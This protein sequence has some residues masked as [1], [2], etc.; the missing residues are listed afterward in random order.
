MEMS[1][2]R[3]LNTGEPAP[4][5]HLIF[6]EFFSEPA[7]AYDN[8]DIFFKWSRRLGSASL[9]VYRKSAPTLGPEPHL[10]GFSKCFYICG[11]SKYMVE[12]D[13]VKSAIVEA[14][15]RHQKDMS[16]CP[17][18]STH[19]C[20]MSDQPSHGFLLTLRDYQR[21][22][23]NWMEKIESGDESLYYAP[24][25]ATF[26]DN[27]QYVNVL[28]D[29]VISR[30]DM[31]GITMR[32]G[33]IA[34]KPGVGKTI[35]T[36]ALMHQRP[37]AG[38]DD[39]LYSLKEERFVSR[40]TIIFAPNNLC[41]QWNQEI[42][43]CFGDTLKVHVLKGKASLMACKLTD[44]LTAD[45]IVV[46]YALLVNGCY[47]GCK[48]SGRT[49]HHYKS[50]WNFSD[51]GAVKK[52]C[53]SKTGVF[54][55]TWIHF[56]RVVCD[57]FHEIGDKATAIVQQI[58]SMSSDHFWGLTGTPRLESEDSVQFAAEFLKCFEPWRF[59]KFEAHR[60]IRHR[61][62]CNEPAPDF[63][64]PIHEST[65]IDLSAQER[66]MYH[67]MK[68]AGGLD[69]S[70]KDLLM[71][72]SHYQIAGNV[73]ANMGQNGFGGAGAVFPFG[74]VQA[75]FIPVTKPRTIEEVIVSIQGHRETQIA[76]LEKEI[77]GLQSQIRTYEKDIREIELAGPKNDGDDED[78][79][80]IN[81][82]AETPLNDKLPKNRQKKRDRLKRSIAAAE[83]QIEARLAKLGPLR[84]Q[85]NFFQNFIDGYI[86]RTET[87]SCPVCLADDEE[88]MENEVLA[89]LPC[90]H[91]LCQPC[92]AAVFALPGVDPSCPQCRRPTAR[93]DVIFLA[94][95]RTE[96]ERKEAQKAAAEKRKQA[97]AEAKSSKLSN[98]I[99]TE[100]EDGG[101]AE[102]PLDFDKFGTKLSNV[103]SFI[104]ETLSA[105]PDHRVIVFVQWSN[106]A[107]YV[108]KAL[109]SLLVRTARLYGGWQM[110]ERALR[111]FAVGG[112]VRVLLLS[113][114]DSVSGLNLTHATHVVVLHPFL[115]DVESYAVAAERQGVAR[116]LRMGQTRTVKVVRFVV[117]DTVEEVMFLR[118]RVAYEKIGGDDDELMDVEDG[119]VVA[120]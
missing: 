31:A 8:V 90:G 119:M 101:D 32:G 116:V 44:M 69:P 17:I 70:L 67:Q 30:V 41:D 61:V 11:L 60:F 37:F 114:T 28:T 76:D 18:P 66:I 84:T 45:I 27:R 113:A 75:P 20:R 1:V 89:V 95:R 98:K 118:R 83:V 78:D 65:M 22:S 72:C 64:D 51:S 120:A 21:R 88:T 105:D 7:T 99:Q 4:P 77:E 16:I 9:K 85:H 13:E 63:P 97:I 110:R 14:P 19:D 73:L 54:S 56:H 96:R 53:D 35:T 39:F 29:H 100:S 115:S 5:V 94:P 79:D 2:C 36:L 93:D 117:R 46:S 43:K 40:A 33:I 86:T 71:F 48:A 42:R 34:D 55:F 62:R 82:V 107:M 49:L 52:F 103:A 58:Q 92:S 74:G 109:S 112:D 26:D 80:E 23:L 24:N 111:S 59:L 91:I 12:Y 6:P 57:E 38:P 10:D 81:F 87:L 68:N 108:T 106:L 3:Y 104:T 102:E 47:K 15:P 50:H 25:Y